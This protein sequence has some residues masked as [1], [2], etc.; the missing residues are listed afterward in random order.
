MKTASELSA[1]VGEVVED[2]PFDRGYW[3]RVANLIRPALPTLT[4]LQTY[5]EAEQAIRGWDTA[6]RE[7]K[8]AQGRE[9]S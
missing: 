6:D 2:H 3:S 4:F 9:K 1:L 5:R 8:K 7:I